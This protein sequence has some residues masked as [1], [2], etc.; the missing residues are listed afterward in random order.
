MEITSTAPPNVQRIRQLATAALIAALLC[1]SAYITVP[2]QPVPVTLQVF[3]VVLA[4]L[5]LT[6]PW[7]TAAMA[8]YLLLGA[9][10]LPVF[11][12]AK[13]G[14]GVLAGPTGGYLVGFLL[15]ALVSSLVRE[16]L[17]RTQT[18]PVLA[19]GIAAGFAILVVY[20]VGTVQLAMVTGMSAAEAVAVGVV[21]FLVLDAA[22]A[23]A[24]V[25]VATAVRRARG[26]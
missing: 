18:R 9:A 4:G 3:F 17:V 6:A 22:K 16:A 5:L 20:T 2:L 26:A 1:A 21:P 10:G 14:L 25:V 8:V 19:D 11:A 13:G 15:A 23:A 7:A 24:A 12:G